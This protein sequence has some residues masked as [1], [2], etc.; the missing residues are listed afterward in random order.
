MK[1]SK[2]IIGLAAATA[3]VAGAGAMAA[4]PA[5][6]AK[7]PKTSG[8]TILDIKKAAPAL[9]AAGITITVDKPATFAKGIIGFPV[10]G[11]ADTINH[12]GSVTFASTANPAGITGENPVIAINGN[13]ATIT[14]S[15]LGN[16]VPLL[17]VKHVKAN[18]TKRKV[19]KGKKSWS[20]KYTTVI[21]GDLHLTSS[22]PIVDLFNSGL[23]V[24]IFEAGM[25]L[26]TTKTTIVE[27]VQCAKP[28]AKSCK[29][30]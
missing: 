14:L 12:S 10:T 16:P 8:K 25:G 7:A 15:V 9:A 21:R 20:V 23:G 3:L 2:K 22:Q 4:T 26:G 30:A 24:T 29:K 19:V 18:K 11:D 27:T 6:A 1:L 28:N 13:T 17:D 5:T